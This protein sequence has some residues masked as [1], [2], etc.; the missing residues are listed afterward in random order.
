[1]DM[2]VDILLV[3]NLIIVQDHLKILVLRGIRF[4]VPILNIMHQTWICL[5]L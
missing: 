2:I 3:I 4:F 5:W 1:M